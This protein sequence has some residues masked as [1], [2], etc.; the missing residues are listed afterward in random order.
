MSVKNLVDSF[1]AYANGAFQCSRAY[2]QHGRPPEMVGREAQRLTF[3]GS[4]S[5]GAP[6]V[7]NS[8]WMK[9]DADLDQAVA[10][11]VSR[12]LEQKT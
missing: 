6:F 10:A 12:M 9:C 2:L 4:Y 1:N 5:T 7:V 11:V 3:E 8:P